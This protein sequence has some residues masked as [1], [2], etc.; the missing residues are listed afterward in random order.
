MQSVIFSSVWI[1]NLFLL[2]S[3]STANLTKKYQ[4]FA[5]LDELGSYKLYWSVDRKDESISFAVEVQTTGWVGFGI[6]SGN[7]KM[8][9]S[10]LVIGWVKDCKGYLTVSNDLGY[11]VKLHLLQFQLVRQ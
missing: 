3:L 4:H 10:D 1:S 8:K 6:S 7:G 9:G 5:T 2:F 11:E